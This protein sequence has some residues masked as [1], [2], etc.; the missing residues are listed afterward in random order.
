MISLIA[1]SAYLIVVLIQIKKTAREAEM[2]LQKV[3]VELAVVNKVSGK[4]ADITDKVSAPVLSVISALVYIVSGVVKK[5][6]K[7]GEE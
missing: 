3:N 4:V 2:V 7:C 1:V 5:K 6:K